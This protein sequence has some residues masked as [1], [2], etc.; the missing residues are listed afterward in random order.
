MPGVTR[1]PR[2]IANVAVCVSAPLA[3]LPASSDIPILKLLASRD[4]VNRIRSDLRQRNN[5]LYTG[6]ADKHT[7]PPPSPAEC[8]GRRVCVHASHGGP[9]SGSR[10]HSG[11]PLQSRLSGAAKA[12]QTANGLPPVC[13]PIARYALPPSTARSFGI[14][15]CSTGW[16]VCASRGATS[17]VRKPP[18]CGIELCYQ[19]E[20]HQQN[21]G[22]ES[23]SA[24]A[25]ANT[26]CSG[27]LWR[28]GCANQ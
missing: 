12:L 26:L 6:N 4:Q 7:R 22:C 17:L 18:P 13:A 28:S 15:A 24:S 25:I 20:Q 1:T 16:N 10:A 3:S 27:E 19:D 23:M 11:E 21:E 5:E 8:D 2:G 9:D 14:P